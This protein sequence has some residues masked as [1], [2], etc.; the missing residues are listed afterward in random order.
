MEADV[1]ADEVETKQGAEDKHTANNGT[2]SGSKNGC[3]GLTV[4]MHENVEEAPADCKG[5]GNGKAR[6]ANGTA[7][8]VPEV[9][10]IA[11]DTSADPSPKPIHDIAAEDISPGAEIL[12]AVAT[13]ASAVRKAVLS[14]SSGNIDQS[15]VQASR[16]SPD[17][18]MSCI[19]KQHK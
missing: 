1:I 7:L 6:H 10:D 18:M 9:K 5:E 19:L 8:A 15:P 14:E 4:T 11:E 3:S 2:S 16:K 13:I 12:P 17:G